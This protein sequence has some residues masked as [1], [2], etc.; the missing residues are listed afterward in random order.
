MFR[1]AN[2]KAEVAALNKGQP[3]LTMAQARKLMRQ[4]KREALKG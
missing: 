2:D 3:G 4:A 1:Y